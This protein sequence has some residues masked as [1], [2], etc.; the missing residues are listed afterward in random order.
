MFIH[1][2]QIDFQHSHKIYLILFCY[3]KIT[4]YICGVELIKIMDLQKSFGILSLDGK[5]I[6]FYAGFYS[7]KD[8]SGIVQSETGTEMNVHF[9]QRSERFRNLVK[10]IF[11]IELKKTDK[12]ASILKERGLYLRHGG[13]VYCDIRLFV[14]FYALSCDEAMV[15]CLQKGFGI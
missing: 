11:G 6:S 2:R 12:I 1:K 13:D 14:I 7:L 8:L 10:L 4:S 9:I 15:D 5:P 3:F